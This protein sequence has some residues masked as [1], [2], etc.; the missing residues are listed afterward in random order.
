MFLLL[1]TASAHA[2]P[3]WNMPS[4]SSSSTTVN[5]HQSSNMEF[6][7]PVAYEGIQSD[8][9][10]TYWETPDMGLSLRLR[11]SYVQG[12]FLICTYHSALPQ[13]KKIIVKRLKPNGLHCVS[14]G[15]GVFQCQQ[16]K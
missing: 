1:S 14:D 7:C 9:L 13:R 15:V 11:N 10:P 3:K 6:K 2:G 12:T 8:K 16:A 5:H 4:L